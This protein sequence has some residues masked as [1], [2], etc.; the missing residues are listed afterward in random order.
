MLFSYQSFDYQ[1]Y[2]SNPE[3]PSD[4]VGAKSQPKNE[5]KLQL[6]SRS[7]VSPYVRFTYRG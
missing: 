1:A 6:K 7:R 2:P 3:S 5:A 4:E